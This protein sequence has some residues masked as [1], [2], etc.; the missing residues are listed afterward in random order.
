[1]RA[2]SP[3]A[4]AVATV[5]AEL[6]GDA[7][8][9]LTEAEGARRLAE[10]GPN[11]LTA[12]PGTPHWKR[13]A[14]QFGDPLVLLLLV[15]AGVSAAV[16]AV[17][18]ES[19]WPHEAI[20]ILL[21]VVFNAA[22]GLYQEGKAEQALAALRAMT[23]PEATVVREGRQRRLPAREVVPGDLLVVEEGDAIAADARV[24]ESVSLHTLEAAL[25]GES[26]PVAKSIGEV[27]A[28]A[29][30]GDRH[31]LLFAGT[32]VASGHG[33]ALVT[34]T[35]M[36]TELGR[37]A[38]LLRETEE[39]ETPLQRE[40]ERLG[41]QLGLAVVVIAAVVCATLLAVHGVEDVRQVVRILLFGV[42][43]A[44]AAAPEGLAAV[45]TVVLA[46]GVTR[47][48]R[49]GAIVRRLPAVETL[50]A[51][52]VIAT[53]KTGTLTRNQ[54]AV[55]VILPEGGEDLLLAAVLA[56]NA[57]SD[58]ASGDPTETALLTAARERGFAPET[59]RRLYPRVGE[60]PFSSERKRMSTVHRFEGRTVLFAK[61]APAVILGLC[62]AEWV[63]GE[64]RPLPEARRAEL[65]A[66][67]D[68]LAAE[69]MRTLAMARG[70]GPEEAEWAYVGLV[71][72]S[73]PPR[74]EAAPSVAK[75]IAAGIRPVMI[76]GDHPETALAIAR[77]IGIDAEAGAVTGAGLEAVS[78]EVVA[79]TSVFAR[80][81]PEHKLRIVQ[82]LRE[83]GAVVAMTGDGV[84][85][86]P[87]LKA[88]DIGVAMGITGTAVAK[89][90]ADLI[91][92]D[93]N[94]ATIVAAVEEGRAVFDNIRK[95][96]RYL[97]SSNIGEVFTIF[98]G[99]V[100]AGP[101][102]LSQ[103]AE[104][105]LPLLATQILWINL[106]T[107]GAPAL[108][109][110]VDPA[111]GDLMQRPPR[112]REQ[113]VIHRPMLIGVGIIG[114]V[115]AAGTL[116]TFD[117]S[118]PGGWIEGAGTLV[119]GR[120]MAFTTLMLFQI[121]NAFNCRSDHESAFRGL[122]ANRWLWG[123]TALSVALHFL[124]LYVPTLRTAFSTVPLGAGDWAVATAVASSV[125]WVSEAMKL[126]SRAGWVRVE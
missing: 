102:G 107:D 90:A 96:L 123:A 104:F 28:E 29:P 24:I 63:D 126:A 124:V 10:A 20:V 114:L 12:A 43:L 8:A 76:T 58:G 121:F 55:R 51:A 87:A 15:A 35:G 84:N 14:A 118:L 108:A 50:G 82:A 31:N 27:A 106:V 3:H 98:F 86:A 97:L 122:F 66:A 69:A 116:L 46:M 33:R 117:A 62:T 125:L 74:A 68:R 89:E 38:G 110:G 32:N 71:G 47:M 59:V 101:L 44:V 75:A 115:M 25:T 105:V 99:V 65:L 83:G 103:G 112:P 54:M 48:A 42:V 23:V 21:I 37:I 93:D 91:L 19:A 6:G 67:A 119:Y 79:R 73:D 9:G 111:A 22:L 40:M 11:E 7:R 4:K 34:A 13:I 92:T 94:F 72:M 57:P 70:D 61:G 17:E 88:A 78:R 56:N 95:F 109:L 85:D 64:R 2:E 16:W 30:L 41:K 80:V 120:T 49:R 39:Q 36:E 52:T 53:D 1:M 18:R 100:L 81:N 26:V 113:G 60:H 5:L 45:V 77:E